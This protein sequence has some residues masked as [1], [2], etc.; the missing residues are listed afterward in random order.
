MRSYIDLF[1]MCATL[2]YL[3]RS[4]LVYIP[5]VQLETLL[6]GLLAGPLEMLLIAQ[7]GWDGVGCGWGPG[8]Q[9]VESLSVV[10]HLPCRMRRSCPILSS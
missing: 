3:V 10:P 9:A 7:G 2:I 6:N 8:V 4:D 5:V 1:S